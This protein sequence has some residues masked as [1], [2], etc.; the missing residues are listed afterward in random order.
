MDLL[1]EPE[2]SRFT[3][4]AYV[5]FQQPIEYLNDYDQ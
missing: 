5:N 1:F 3:D 2:F 4:A